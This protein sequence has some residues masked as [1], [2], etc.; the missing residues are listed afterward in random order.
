MRRTQSRTSLLLVGVLFFGPP[1]FAAN[2]Q[3]AQ[4]GPLQV[5]STAAKSVPLQAADV[6]QTPVPRQAQGA[7]SQSLSRRRI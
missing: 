5:K 3:A 1:A 6:R 7:A 4:L 2:G